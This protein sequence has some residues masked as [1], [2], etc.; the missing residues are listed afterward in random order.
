MLRVQF[1]SVKYIHS[2]V[3]QLSRNF[4]PC[5][6]KS[7]PTKQQFPIFPSLQPLVTAIVLFASMN[8]TTS[9]TSYKWSYMLRLVYFASCHV[10]KIHPC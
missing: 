7:V 10:L 1:S 4:S 6:T 5:K 8:F 2:A 9:D 3:K